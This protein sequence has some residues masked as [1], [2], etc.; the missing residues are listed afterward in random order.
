MNDDIR[1]E[2]LRGLYDL[3]YIWTNNTVAAKVI[4][5]LFKAWSLSLPARVQ[6]LLIA[7]AQVLV[8]AQIQVFLSHFCFYKTVPHDAFFHGLC[9]GLSANTCGLE[10]YNGM[11]KRFQEYQYSKLGEF[12]LSMAE[13]LSILS[14]ARD[15][16]IPGSL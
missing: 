5:G 16:S 8:V 9:M 6:S 10:T 12:L 1:A 11:I 7:P 2:V 3:K 14:S 4:V 13:Y 15:P